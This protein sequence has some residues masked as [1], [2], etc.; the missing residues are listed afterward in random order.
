M[1]MTTIFHLCLIVTPLV[2]LGHNILLDESWG[3]GFWSLSEGATDALTF[4]VFICTAFFLIR[5][6]AVARVRAI[7]SAEDYLILLIAVA[8]FVTGYMAYHQWLD[9]RTV[10]LLH[11]LAGEVML[12]ALPFT[13]LG[14]MLFFFLYRLMIGSEHSFS[15]G[16]RSW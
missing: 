12:A 2:V 8:P 6:I 10:I 11:I 14:H 9:Y 3:V 7:T 1:V 4:I 16:T 13:K 15:Q 5:R